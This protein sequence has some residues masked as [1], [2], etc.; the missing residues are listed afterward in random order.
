MGDDVIFSEEE[1]GREV[2]ATSAKHRDPVAASTGG[3]REVERRGD[4]PMPR[5]CT[6]SLDAVG[7][8]EAKQTRSPCPSM[9]SPVSSPPTAD[10][11]E[12]VGW[13]EERAGTRASP[14]PVPAHD[15]QPKDALPVAPI[16]VSR[17]EGRG[18]A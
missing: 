6:A 9:A 8:W 15:S 18:D 5:K 14:G 2:V 4:V 7:E 11:A 10:V 1:E 3:E 13:S 17:A 16:R 12:Q